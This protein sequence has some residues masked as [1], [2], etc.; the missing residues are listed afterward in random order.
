MVINYVN[1]KKKL[2]IYKYFSKKNDIVLMSS[3][4]ALNRR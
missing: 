4:S 2:V 3:V 1:W